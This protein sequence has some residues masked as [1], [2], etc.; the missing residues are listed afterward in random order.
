MV[1]VVVVVVVVGCECQR[2]EEEEGYSERF[3]ETRSSQWC[4]LGS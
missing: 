1:V 3:D 2:V 4:F